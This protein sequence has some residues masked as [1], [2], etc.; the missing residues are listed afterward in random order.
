MS[1]LFVI[2]S[3]E[4]LEVVQKKSFILTLFLI[5]LL[6]GGAMVLPTLLIDS[7]ESP[8]QNISIIDLDGRDI[9]KAIA[10]SLMTLKLSDDQPQF[11]IEETSVAHF[12]ND[13][14]WSELRKKLEERVEDGSLD[15][16]L[17]LFPG[18]VENDS[19]EIISKKVELRATAAARRTITAILTDR[20]LTAA[21]IGIPKDSL[22]RLTRRVNLITISPSGHKRNM[23]LAFLGSLMFAM[24]VVI[25]VIN[26]GQAIMRSIIEEKNSRIIEVM[27]SSVTPFQLML[28]KILGLGGAAMTQ[29]ALWGAMGMGA[30]I[31]LGA[32]IPA[33]AMQSLNT[34]SNPIF[35]IFA[36]LFVMSAFFL[37]SVMFCGIGAMVNSEKDA[38]NL[39]MPI[40]L[41]LMLSM[42]LAPAVAS[43]SG[44][45][46][47]TVVSSIPFLS[48]SIMIS[49]L[50][51]SPPETFTL[52]DPLILQACLSLVGVV[53]TT[54]LMTW[55]VARIFRIGILMYGKRA[56]F[57]EIIRWVRQT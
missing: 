3:K 54:L 35:L 2:I 26:Y 52:S 38:Q 40:T 5:P 1:K 32:K 22:R 23:K 47:V 17:I 10:D 27:I 56:T 30:R 33:E 43:S 31:M 7:T 51:I 15:A 24:V 11:A 19:I 50:S 13:S 21:N 53:V 55:L 42:M 46:W 4:Y 41:M 25:L 28:G 49:R 48:P 34:L 9:G 45:G 39:M 12:S 44:S 6:V 29:M 8:T 20:R 18:L 37:Y 57:P 36:A 14:A 16:A